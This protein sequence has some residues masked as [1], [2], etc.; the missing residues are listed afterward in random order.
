MYFTF[1]IDI[2]YYEK[3]VKKSK[4]SNIM[5]FPL[6]RKVR[7]YPIFFFL[8]IRTTLTIMT[9]LQLL[10]RLFT[11]RYYLDLLYCVV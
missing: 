1:S 8:L 3:C 11:S 5:S 6:T 7:R 10:L 4:Y 2:I 9:K